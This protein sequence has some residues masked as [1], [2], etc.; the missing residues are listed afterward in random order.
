M[1]VKKAIGT[2][3]IRIPIPICLCFDLRVKKPVKGKR[4]NEIVT[5][6]PLSKIFVRVRP[7][8]GI[9][10]EIITPKT[11]FTIFFEF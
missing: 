2:K 5:A 9:I 10:I 8:I 7:I 4:I 3:P 1:K 6:K 11:I